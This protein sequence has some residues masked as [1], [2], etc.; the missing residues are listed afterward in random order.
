M[1]EIKMK[2]KTVET[3][4]VAACEFRISA[5]QRIA[6]CPGS[7][8]A[9]AGLPNRESEFSESGKRIHSALAAYFGSGHDFDKAAANLSPDEKDITE[10]L[11]Q[12]TKAFLDSMG[13]QSSAPVCES[14]VEFGDWRGHPDF[15]C[16][17]DSGRRLVILDWKSGW[18]D[19]PPAESNAQLRGYFAGAIT[20]RESGGLAKI[21]TDGIDYISE[22]AVALITPEKTSHCIYPPDSFAAAS[23]EMNGIAAAAKV[24]NAPRIPSPSA[25]QYCRACGTANCPESMETALVVLRGRAVDFSQASPEWLLSVARAGKVVAGIVKKATAEMEARLASDP[26]SVPG[27]RLEPGAMVRAVRDPA[28][29][30]GAILAA[31][32]P[33]N[34]LWEGECLKFTLGKLERAL[35][36]DQSAA[37][38]DGH[39]EFKQNK[40]SIEF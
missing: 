32:I 18:G 40:P 9:S 6:D 11:V 3:A 25:C 20:A 14:A 23:E 35:G 36:K 13:G 4:P 31:G 5:A 29:L 15:I 34:R 22:V 7:V 19:I 27:A 1:D 21:A 39:I 33:E 2:K 28:G 12:K 17:C 24:P 26:A 37:L 10:T 30:F 16:L 38:L 8:L